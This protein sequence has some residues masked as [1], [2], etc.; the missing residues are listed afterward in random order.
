MRADSR[1]HVRARRRE[2]PRNSNQAKRPSSFSCM[3]T[4]A[5]KRRTAR[6]HVTLGVSAQCSMRGVV[7]MPPRT[8]ATFPMPMTVVRGCRTR[9]ST[10]AGHP[11][12]RACGAARAGGRTC[13]RPRRHHVRPGGAGADRPRARLRAPHWQWCSSQSDRTRC[14]LVSRSSRSVRRK[15]PNS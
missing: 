5:A 8:P 6:G 7:R 15:E 12:A 3:R 1:A 10:A 9:P 14:G 13:R 4:A 11:C 2:L